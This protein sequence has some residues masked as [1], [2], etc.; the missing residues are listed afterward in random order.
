METKPIP[1]VRRCRWVYRVWQFVTRLC[2]R[3]SA[4]D[5]ALVRNVLPGL[6]LSWFDALSLGDQ[7][8]SLCVLRALRQQGD[9]TADLEQAALL[10][11]VG[12]AGGGLTLAHRAVI[13]LLRALHPVWLD[14]LT[15]ND[16]TSWRYPFYIHRH[17]AELG[18]RRCA[19]AGCSSLTVWLVRHHE[20]PLPDSVEPTWS[21]ALAVLRRADDIC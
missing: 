8:H 14:M 1:K 9:I 21:E 6:A 19:E 4:I 10:H 12:K 20:G 11:D 18:A 5:W 16:P 15:T 2:V 7:L 17:H 3:R 13:V